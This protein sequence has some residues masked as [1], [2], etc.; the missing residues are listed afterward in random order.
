MIEY[1]EHLSKPFPFCR[2]D[3]YNINGDICFGEITFYP[4]GAMQIVEPEE[5]ERKMGDWIDLKSEKIIYK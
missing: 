5:W 2:V 1:A 4:G 3:L